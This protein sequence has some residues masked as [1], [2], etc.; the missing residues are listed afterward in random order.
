MLLH[1]RRVTTAVDLSSA[2]AL[3]QRIADDR[4]VLVDVS[5]EQRAQLQ[6]LCG[7]IARPDLKD[8][9]K[10]QKAL[11]Q[12][13]HQQKKADDD[14]RRKDTGIRHLRAQPVFITPPALQLSAPVDDTETVDH[15]RVRVSANH[16]VGVDEAI[17]D[18]SD[19]G[20]PL[21][22]DLVHDTIARWHDSEVLKGLFSP[23]EEG[24]ALL[25][26]LEFDSLVLLL[27]IGLSS[28]IDLN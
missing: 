11:L 23:L 28:D 16:R 7:V 1:T 12:Q 9:K 5:A 25:V 10:L 14:E 26:T 4:A 2:L 20:E 3:L 18:E 17:S 15:G 27:S 6:R 13:E 24:K 21:K 8:R 22:I 19:T